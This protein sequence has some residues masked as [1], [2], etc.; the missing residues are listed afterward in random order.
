MV[1]GKRILLRALTTK[2]LPIIRK[3]INDR[4][5]C[6][7]ILRYLPVTDFDH[8]EWF[9]NLKKDKSQIHF[10]VVIK[11]TNK[12]IGNVSLRNINWKDRN[13]DLLIY[14]GDRKSWGQGYGSEILEIFIDYCFKVLN[15]HKVYLRVVA[16]NKNAIRLYEKIGFVRE[17]EFKDEVFM[18]GRY[19]DVL[20]MAI[21]N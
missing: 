9:K 1:I 16:Y 7:G 18:D 11:K 17:G 4:S 13:G 12:Y 10:A 6:K 20:R 5:I 14:I 3:W 21:I 2:D 8:K 19:H 15:L